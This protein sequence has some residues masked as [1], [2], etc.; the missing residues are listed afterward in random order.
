MSNNPSNNREVAMAQSRF[1]KPSAW[2][3]GPTIETTLR[4]HWED[5]RP[6]ETSIEDLDLRAVVEELHQE[7]GGKRPACK[8][9]ERSG[10]KHY[11][12][13]QSPAMERDWA[14]GRCTTTD[15]LFNSS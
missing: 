7:S 9:S 10:S 12:Q 3:S 4:L 1:L 6:P 8:A 15:R 5:S 2:T 14:I 13:S 11:S